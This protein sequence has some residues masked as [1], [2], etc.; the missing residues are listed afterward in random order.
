MRVG[1]A[2]SESFTS[3]TASRLLFQFL[4]KGSCIAIFIGLNQ[5]LNSMGAFITYLF[6]L[7]MGFQ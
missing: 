4:Q 7:T 2:I 1:A 6:P 3:T 5:A